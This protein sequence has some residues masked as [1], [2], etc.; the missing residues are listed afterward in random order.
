MLL[1]T[2]ELED[3]KGPEKRGL[4]VSKGWLQA[5]AFVVLFG[6]FVMGLLAY[7]TYAGEAPIPA[8]TITSDRKVL[9]T[10]ADILAGQQLFLKNGLMEY[11]SIFG[12]GAYLGPD[13]T[14][15]LSSSVG[16]ERD[17]SIRRREVRSGK[18][19]DD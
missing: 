1:N 17:Q 4:L 9:F 2:T 10:R 6:F 5:V 8:Q 18:R 15:G 19:S 11:G 16:N 12:H 13:Y 14:A 3:F 7:R